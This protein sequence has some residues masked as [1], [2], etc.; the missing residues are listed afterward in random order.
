M[1]LL[2]AALGLY[3]LL[4][5]SVVR[6]TPELGIHLALGARRS[7]VVRSVVGRSVWL[8]MLGTTI[9]LGTAFWLARYLQPVLFEVAP[10]DAT[11]YVVAPIVLL[12]VAVV[13]AAVPAIRAARLDPMRV[14]RAD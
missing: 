13:A 5:Y 10:D 11:I 8:V 6:R 9:G 4:A 3:G 1:T 12:V 14:L 2:L 7:Q